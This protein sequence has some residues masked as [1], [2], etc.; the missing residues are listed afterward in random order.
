MNLAPV[1]QKIEELPAR[2]IR[3]RLMP[4]KGELVYTIEAKT[5]AG[6]VATFQ[7]IGRELVQTKFKDPENFKGSYEETIFTFV[8]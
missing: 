3:A 6:N 8:Q 5:L 7:L 2:V 4:R 1:I